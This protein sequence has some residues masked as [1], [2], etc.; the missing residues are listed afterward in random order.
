[1]STDNDRIVADLL[2]ISGKLRN[3]TV[4]GLCGRAADAFHATLEAKDAEIERLQARLEMYGTH[5][6][7][8][9]VVGG[10][11]Y[12]CNCGFEE[13]GDLS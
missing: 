6:D 4:E 12:P 2:G 8:C 7:S 1:M 3:D 11:T 13:G 5:Q 10:Y 9:A